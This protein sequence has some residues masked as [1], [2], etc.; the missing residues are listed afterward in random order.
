[1]KEKSGDGFFLYLAEERPV[2]SSEDI[3]EIL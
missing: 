3:V 1:M 2:Y